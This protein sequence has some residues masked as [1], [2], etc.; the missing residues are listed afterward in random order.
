[1]MRYVS[2]A[3]LLVAVSAAAQRHQMSDCSRIED[4]A[5]R[6]ACFDH[7][8]PADEAAEAGEPDAAANSDQSAEAAAERRPSSPAPVIETTPDAS[9][10]PARETR[11]TEPSGQADQ[12]P[13]GRPSKGR[14]FGWDERVDITT[15]VVSV[16]H[17][18]R[19]K[20]VFRL[21]N[22]QIWMQATPRLLRIRAGEQV[23]IT[24][25]SVGGYMLRTTGGVTT[26]VERIK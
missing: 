17:R 11:P 6:L 12:V 4:A 21:A 5:A 2:I 3:L 19:Q 1:M 22:G 7:Q 13:S 8:F 16:R 9:P 14:L 24:N 10:E 25:A 20:M 26:R 18:D 15:R 23:T